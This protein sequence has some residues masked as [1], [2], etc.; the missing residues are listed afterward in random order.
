MASLSKTSRYS[1]ITVICLCITMLLLWK[2]ISSLDGPTIRTA[3]QPFAATPGSNMLCRNRLDNAVAPQLLA[4]EIVVRRVYLDPRRRDG[5]SNTTVFLIEAM[6]TKVLSKRFAGCRVGQYVSK[7]VQLRTVTAFR[8]EQKIKNATSSL[9]FVDCYDIP[10]LTNG[11]SASLFYK[12]SRRRA[13]QIPSLKPLLV[14]IP[15]SASKPPAATVAVCVGMIRTGEHT[16]SE[17]GMLYHWLRYQKVIGVDH[18]HMMVENSFVRDGGLQNEVIKQVLR[19][20]YLSIDFWPNWFNFTDI[21][22]PKKLA[23]QDCIYRFQGVYDYIVYA[24]SDDFFVPVKKIKSIKHYLKTWCSGNTGTCRFRWRQYFPDCGWN[25]N[26]ID[27]NG[28]ITKAVTYKQTMERDLPKSAHQLKA[29]VDVG[30][31]VP[32]VLLD[33]YKQARVPITEAYF[34]HIRF[35]WPPEKGC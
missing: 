14:P 2:L 32:W 3:T 16:P 8:W 6:G 13:V 33:G 21:Y 9:A 22:S 4:K 30:T 11:D 20:G 12:I 5:Y 24:D 18:V 25:P 34:A 7:K 28:N 29:L 31:H 35:G 27:R 17:H 23:Y 1:L 15:R 26:F 19:E 10:E